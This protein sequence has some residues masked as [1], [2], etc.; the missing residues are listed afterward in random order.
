MLSLRPPRSG[1]WVDVRLRELN[2]RW[3]ASADTLDGPSPGLGSVAI[4]AV[5]HA[6]EPSD[7]PCGVTGEPGADGA[8]L[9]RAVNDADYRTHDD[10]GIQCDRGTFSGQPPPTE[11]V[12]F[13]R[14]AYEGMSVELGSAARGRSPWL[15]PRCS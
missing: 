13:P 1:F 15:S 10:N 3:I 9:T 7:G 12:Q 2:G 6:L 5:E 14:L 4:E 11:A 8:R